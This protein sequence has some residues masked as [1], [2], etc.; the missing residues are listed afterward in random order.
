MQWDVLWSGLL[1]VLHLLVLAA[2]FLELGAAL[3][4][5]GAYASMRVRTPRGRVE[6]VGLDAFAILAILSAT[7][8]AVGIG[9]LVA[10]LFGAGHAPL[11][12]VGAVGLALA[13]SSRIRVRVTE[14]SAVL[15]RRFAWVTWRRRPISGARAYYDG[16]GDFM[17]PEALYVDGVELGWV[18]KDAD[19][20]VADRFNE[21]V[22]RLRAARRDAAAT[23]RGPR[24][25]AT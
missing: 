12:V 8:V 25:P 20:T 19:E 3:V 2:P 15:E 17:D 16:W 9:A 22:D 23:T 21:A 10:A 13:A 6:L 14:N 4:L 1:V 11:V 24:P 5:T 18:S 7:P